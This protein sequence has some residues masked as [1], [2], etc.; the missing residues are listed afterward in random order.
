MKRLFALI[1]LMA[2]VVSNASTEPWNGR[3]VTVAA[4]TAGRVTNVRTQVSSLF[5]QMLPAAGAG[6]GYVLYAPKGV[7]CSQGTAGTTTIAV[8][9]AATSTAPGGNATVPSN[10]DP[11]GGID[12]SLYCYDGAHSGDTILLSWNLRN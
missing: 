12:A 11:Q 2:L 6:I 8:L 3:I 9:Q 10:P 5:F 1:G 7:T 4:G